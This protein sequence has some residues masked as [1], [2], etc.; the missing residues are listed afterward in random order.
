M[1]ILIKVLILSFGLFNFFSSN[2][3]CLAAESEIKLEKANIDLKDAASL[4]RGAKVFMNYCQG[5]H[6]LKYERY[7]SMAKGIKITDESGEVLKKM[8]RENLLFI[9]DK[10]NDPINSSLLKQNAANWFGT[11]PPDLSLVARARGIDWVYTYM[12]TFYQ[13]D[14]KTWGVNNL[15]FPN[16]AM[17]HVLVDLQGIQKKSGD[18]LILS[19]AGSLNGAEYDKLVTDLVNFL[20]YVS[21]PAKLERKKIGAWVLM[22]LGIFAVFAYLLKREFWKDIK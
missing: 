5:C 18:D 2:N 21:E 13:D 15:V 3:F 22:F 20:S 7:D 11:Q 6:S 12:K 14:S 8:V 17:P 4:Q 19:K 9:G 1:N 10:L 16:S